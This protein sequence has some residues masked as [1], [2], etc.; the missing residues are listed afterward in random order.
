MF[1]DLEF[2]KTALNAITTKFR[3]VR[4]DVD[5]VRSDVDVVKRGVPDWNESNGDSHAYIKNKPCYD[6]IEPSGVIYSAN[7]VPS[8]S[9]GFVN[10]GD[11]GDRILIEGEEYVLT[12]DGIPN[13][14]TCVLSDDGYLHVHTIQQN[15]SGGDLSADYSAWENGKSSVKLEGPTRRY[16]KLDTRF[17]DAVTS[18]NKET[19]EVQITP[20]KIEA[21][22]VGSLVVS[23]SILDSAIYGTYR[24]KTCTWLYLGGNRFFGSATAADTGESYF[25]FGP[26]DTILAGIKMPTS[27]NQAANKGYVDATV[28]APRDSIRLYSSTEG[29]T[30]QFE[31]TVNDD[32]VISAAEVAE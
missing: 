5:A 3:R 19:G 7:P 13:T 27:D 20:E 8:G 9:S 1:T 25:Y 2:I 32:G 24:G 10:L 23:Q 15:P 12:I 22:K 14:Y 29:S 30:K 18:V 11:P 31:L 4:S 6:Y 28:A 21:A 16:K 17:Y 26:Y